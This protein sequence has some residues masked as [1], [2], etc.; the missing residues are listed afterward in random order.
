MKRLAFVLVL[1]LAACSDP[2]P[3]TLQGR[4]EGTIPAAQARPSLPIEIQLT[5]ADGGY[6]FVGTVDDMEWTS[7]DVET[8]L[9]GNAVIIYFFE[10]LPGDRTWIYEGTW[11]DDKDS[12]AGSF[13]SGAVAG[14]S[15]TLRRAR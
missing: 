15:V 11:S 14:S 8:R 4:W 1:A 2:K 5:T 10:V 13:T 6:F 9:A 12:I 7:L 3:P